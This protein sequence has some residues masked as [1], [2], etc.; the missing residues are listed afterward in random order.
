MAF[1]NYVVMAYTVMACAV[2]AYIFMAN[3]V[4]AYIV[5]ASILILAV[6]LGCGC[7]QLVWTRMGACLCVGR[8]AGTDLATRR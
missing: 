1:A 2:M 6:F 5:I 3:I 8:D 7:G 4:M